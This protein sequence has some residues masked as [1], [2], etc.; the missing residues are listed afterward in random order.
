[1]R[2]INPS[3]IVFFIIAILFLY[4]LGFFKSSPKIQNIENK[5]VEVVINDDGFSPDRVLLNI[6]DTVKWVN[7][8]DRPHWPAS[9]PHPTHTLY[10][11]TGGC[12]SS[13]LDACKG[14][15]KGETYYFKFNKPGVWPMH[16]HLSPGLVMVVEVGDNQ[17]LTQDVDSLSGSTLSEQFRQ[18]SYSE[19]V[20][21]IKLMAKKDP[22][23]AW[24][25]LKNVFIVDGQVV[26][27]A[28]E[29]S[30]II[31][32]ASYESSGLEGIKICDETFAFGCFHGVTEEM[33]LKQGTK[34]IKEIEE[35]C[36]KAFPPNLSQGYT[37]CIHGT[38]HGIYTWESGNV[39]KSLLDCDIFSE[40]Y[41]SYCYD[42]VFMENSGE[43]QNIKIDE[44]NPWKLCAGLD[45][46]YHH[47][48]ARY[49]SQIFLRPGGKQNSLSVVGIYC[50][51]APT[52]DMKETCFQS[53]GFFVSQT[54]LGIVEKIVDKCSNMPDTDSISICTTGAAIET[55]FQKYKDYNES[56]HILCNKLSGDRKSICLRSVD[57]MIQ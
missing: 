46:R 26:G 54:S 13:L 33:L 45:E 57:N 39:N 40:I 27:N 36:L 11:E 24:K 29:F 52:R 23:E 15:L 21:K 10:G 42:G 5:E 47:S 3:S 34:V 4:S 44:N 28:H 35:G 9:N 30:H 20:K 8:G 48:C 1:M 19:Q 50:S 43:G 22:G 17:S 55:V 37:G 41:R 31:G 12:I 38:G 53:L 2:R 56:A 7:K 18:L 14:L 49:Q 32:N 25:Y 16:D 6:G 51:K